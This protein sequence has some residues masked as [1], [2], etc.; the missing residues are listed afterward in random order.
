MIDG[1]PALNKIRWSPSGHQIAIG[2]DQGRI[3]LF[4]LNEAYVSAR[5]D[6][7]NKLC[8]VL[9][10]LKENSNQAEETGGNPNNAGGGNIGG[11]PLPSANVSP[12]NFLQPNNVAA[13]LPSVKSEPAFDYRNSFSTPTTINQASVIVQNVKVSPHSTK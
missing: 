11:N 3:N 2:D 4:D 1:N 6:D 12:A 7:W 10:D 13:S 5:A 8:K 9:K